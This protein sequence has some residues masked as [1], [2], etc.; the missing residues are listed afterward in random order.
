MSA[1]RTFSDDEIART[2][3]VYQANG[4][5]AKKTALQLGVSRTT[6]RSWVTVAN[7]GIWKGGTGQPRSVA[8]ALVALEVRSLSD[9]WLTAANRCVDLANE[10]LAP[11]EAVKSSTALTVK[12]LLVSAAVATEKHQ[13]LVGGPTSRNE[14]VKVSLIAPD[15]LRDPS[16]HVIEGR[17]TA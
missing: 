9:K 14:S 3:A 17:R 16:L 5:N 12:N 4:G 2:L 15:A 6:L 13:L 8:P 11:D 7:G 1:H 10:A